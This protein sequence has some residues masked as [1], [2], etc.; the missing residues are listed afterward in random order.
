MTA[1]LLISTSDTLQ[2][3]WGW[4][5]VFLTLIFFLHLLVMNIF[6]GCSLIC[7]FRHVAGR[8]SDINRIIAGKLPITG[9]FT[10]NFGV[11]TWYW[12]RGR[13]RTLRLIHGQPHTL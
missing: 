9:T 3:S 4:F 6:L 12:G 1:A 2:V 7:F 8:S 10:I 13:I 5:Q 11:G